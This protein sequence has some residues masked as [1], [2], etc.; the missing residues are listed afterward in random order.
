MPRSTKGQSLLWL[1]IYHWMEKT[2]RTPAWS[3]W[4][5]ERKGGKE[6]LP[7]SRKQSLNST[8]CLFSHFGPRLIPNGSFATF[9]ILLSKIQKKGKKNM[10][11]N[12]FIFH[13]FVPTLVL[14]W[15]DRSTDL[16]GGGKAMAR[17]GGGSPIILTHIRV[18]SPSPRVNAGRPLRKCSCDHKMHA[19]SFPPNS[20]RS[21][22][23]K[24]NPKLKY[25]Y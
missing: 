13:A 25:Q 22:F 4:M 17:D 5:G 10:W 1:V 18:R 7:Q 20:R 16:L 23:Q 15:W 3:P 12:P 19:S 11:G 24:Q 14:R 6:N 8:D 21:L 9:I 2:K